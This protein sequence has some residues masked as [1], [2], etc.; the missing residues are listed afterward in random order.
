MVRTGSLLSTAV[1][2]TR[3]GGPEVLKVRA[4]DIAAPEPGEVRVR[5]EAAGISY[6]DLLMCQGLHPE[7]R[8]AP[9]VPGWDV[10]GE[11][12]SVGSEIRNVAVGDRVA[13]LSIVGGWAEHA[14]V[15]GSLVVPVPPAL[16]STAAVCLVMDYIVAYQMLTRSTSVRRSNTV[17][18]QGAG[19]GVGTAL[20]QLARPMGVQVLGT[21]REKKRSHI[22]SEGGILIDFER[23]DVVDRCHELTDGQ[24]VDA[25]FDGIGATARES[26]RAVRPGGRLVWFGMVTLL[27]G[28]ARDLR[29]SARTV[30]NTAAVFA[31]NL[32]PR[33]KRTSLYSIQELARRHPDW[34]RDDL[35]ALL[36]MLADGHIKPHIAA[37]WKLDEVPAAVEALASGGALPGKQVVAVAA[38]RSNALSPRESRLN[39]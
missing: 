17:L 22:E 9:F 8:R 27:S 16:E 26:L 11:V 25:A 4:F 36:A 10:V 2:A 19:G 12:E 5:V 28:G 15:P 37:V 30:A 20:M 35:A 3:H 21:D 7:R 32:R 31:Q 18:I 13:A 14:V 38:V 23:E 39:S 6:A 34:Y 24:G 1:V 29:K 33:G